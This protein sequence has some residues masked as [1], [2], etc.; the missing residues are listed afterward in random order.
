LTHPSLTTDYSEALIE[1]ITPAEHD[2]SITLDKL[3][4]LHRFV[5]A[6]LARDGEML[7]NESMPGLLPAS[8]EGIPIARY[9]NSNIGRLKY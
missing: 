1:I 8:D 4:E 3:D 2:A 7:W 5:Y 9:G 6:V